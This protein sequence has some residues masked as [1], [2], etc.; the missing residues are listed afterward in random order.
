[1]QSIRD[2]KPIIIEGLHLDPGLYLYE[3]GKY[4]VAHLLRNSSLSS[5]LDRR[6]LYQSDSKLLDG[7][8]SRLPIH[9]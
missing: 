5:G 3:F 1:M 4:G 6:E 7:A 2:G 8:Q 9:R